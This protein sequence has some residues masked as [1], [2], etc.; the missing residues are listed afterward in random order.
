MKERLRVQRFRQLS[1]CIIAHKM[2]LCARLDRIWNEGTHSA[3]IYIFTVYCSQEA[4][5]LKIE[6]HGCGSSRT[7]RGKYHTVVRA[8]TTVSSG[9]GQQPQELARLVNPPQLV[10]NSK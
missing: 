3:S 6:A 4:S 5:P 7:R 9:I 2:R 1:T 8:M 10:R